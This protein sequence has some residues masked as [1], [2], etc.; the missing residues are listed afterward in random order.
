MTDTAKALSESR[1]AHSKKDWVTALVQRI[2]A[3]DL[4][5]Q[6][7]DPAWNDDALHPAMPG[8]RARRM[9]RIPGLTFPEVIAKRDAELEAFYRVQTGETPLERVRVAD[10]EIV[11]PKQWIVITEGRTQDCRGRHA[12]QLINFDQRVCQGCG[13]VEELRETKARADT[14]AAKQLAKERP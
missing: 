11:T 4:D 1:R 6:R 13:Q 14:D 8:E 2:R 7:N 3:R 12:R 5:P 9:M 10:P